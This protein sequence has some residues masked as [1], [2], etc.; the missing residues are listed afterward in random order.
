MRGSGQHSLLTVK[1]LFLVLPAA[2]A[3]AWSPPGSFS[4]IP[5]EKML[6]HER[7]RP[8][9]T[10]PLTVK[11]FF[12]VLPHAALELEKGCETKN[13]LNII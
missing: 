11:H 5:E 4:L 13:K 10:L 12:T 7:E 9:T 2:P 1:H 3:A 6:N 8:V